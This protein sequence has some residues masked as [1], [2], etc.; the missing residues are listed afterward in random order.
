MIIS[1]PRR[2]SKSPR[3]KSKSP[4]R[5]MIK[6]KSPQRIDTSNLQKCS[7][8][9]YGYSSKV[10]IT[11]RHRALKKAIDKYGK[12]KVWNKLNLISILNKNRSPTTAHIFD[13][14]K[15]WIKRTYKLSPI[16]E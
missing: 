7:L 10:G 15:K 11:T 5:K 9:K 13:I 6:S 4:R 1:P 8:S 12:H 2:K 3:R 16:K 14:D